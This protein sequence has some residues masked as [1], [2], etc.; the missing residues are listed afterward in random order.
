MEKAGAATAKV[1]PRCFPA[2]GPPVDFGDLATP[3]FLVTVDTEEEFDWDGP[4]TRDCH[5]LTHLRS[6]E[7]FQKLCERNGV[8]PLYL[9]DYPVI[10][11]DFGA[12]LFADW[13]KSGG[14]EVGLQLHPWVNPPFAETVNLRNSYAC[15][16]SPEIER[17]KLAQLY[18]IV[19]R[20]LGIRAL[21]YRAGRYGAGGATPDFLVEMGVCVDTSVR[22]LFDYRKQGGPNH[23]RALQTPY[24]VKPGQLIE[25]PVTSVFGGTFR[26]MG[27]MLFDQVFASDTMRSMLAR[28]GLLERLA[29]TPEGIPADKAIAAIDYAIDGELPILTFSF[30]SPSL[31]A[32]H[33]PYVRSEAELE[34]FYIWWEAVFAHLAK[35]GIMPITI[36]EI[37]AAAFGK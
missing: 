31:A 13:V 3:R 35:R 25:L 28:G 8:K 20:R 2:S 9:V 12:E 14:A 32:G 23:A 34:Q 22:A 5:G 17:A 6:I 19:E 11:D 15:N 1:G 37:K 18:E 33:T 21:S 26:S 4:F 27:P 16:L 30:H 7:P 29:L 36:A 24:W 10:S